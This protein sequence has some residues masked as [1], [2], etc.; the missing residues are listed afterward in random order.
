MICWLGRVPRYCQNMLLPC[1]KFYAVLKFMMK[2]RR[3]EI[4]HGFESHQHNHFF[5][6]NIRFNFKYLFKTGKISIKFHYFPLQ[7]DAKTVVKDMICKRLF[8]NLH[9]SCW[10]ELTWTIIRYII[11][12]F[13][14]LSL[15]ET[16]MVAVRKCSMKWKYNP[17]ITVIPLKINECNTNI[18]LK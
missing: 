9:S 18:T 6:M 16:L 11:T 2:S 15:A 8:L 17:R 10:A 7:I 1:R 12:V 4:V 14:P 13:D 5:A 3:R